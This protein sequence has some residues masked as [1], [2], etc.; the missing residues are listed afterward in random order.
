MSAVF[1][2]IAAFVFAGSFLLTGYLCS[3]ASRFHLLDH[4]NERSLHER[5]TPRTGGLAIVASLLVSLAATFVWQWSCGV[6]CRTT[7]QLLSAVTFWLI[8]QA[9][10]V[11]IIS[12]IDE[13]RG[14]SAAIRFAVHIIAAAG[15]VLGANQVIDAIPIPALGTLRLAW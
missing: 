10:L 9:L 15:I 8:S 12:L 2:V 1:T 7:S 14:V 5:L 6:R 4:P 13:M 3:P 11:I